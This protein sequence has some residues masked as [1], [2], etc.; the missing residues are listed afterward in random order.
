MMNDKINFNTCLDWTIR[1]FYKSSWIDI[2]EMQTRWGELS[3]SFF[4]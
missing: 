3:V 4:K 2:E 1:R